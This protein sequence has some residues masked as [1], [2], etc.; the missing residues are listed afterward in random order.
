MLTKTIYV[1]VE[2]LDYIKS[3]KEPLYCLSQ[4]KHCY[5]F[6]VLIM[7]LKNIFGKV[8]K[9]YLIYNIVLVSG[10]GKEV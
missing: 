1:N 9:I 7:D 6:G 5:Q 8:L 10:C 3:K 2:Q 4:D